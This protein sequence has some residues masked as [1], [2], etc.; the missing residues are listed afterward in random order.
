MREQTYLY[1]LC[2]GRG[3][4]MGNLTDEIPKALLPVHGLPM[5]E[6]SIN[7]F[8]LAF[9]NMKVRCVGGYQ[10]IKL[11]N[12]INDCPSEC[13][14]FPIINAEWNTYGPIVSASIAASDMLGKKIVML[15]NGDTLY[16]DNFAEQ[17][18]EQLCHAKEEIYLIG[19]LHQF[20]DDDAMLLEVEGGLVKKAGKGLE[21]IHIA[22]ESS[23]FIVAV[24]LNYTALLVEKILKMSDE[25]KKQ[26][27]KDG[28]W[29]EVV[30]ALSNDGVSI[31]F[32]EVDYDS[33][34]EC[35]TQ[36]CILHAEAEMNTVAIK[37][38]GG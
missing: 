32:V 2:A 18:K 20:N 38:D 21:P 9:D 4:R 33:W 25:V 14:I 12:W 3:S 22:Y 35:D 24:G 8:L 27:R 15:A 31:N 10:Y 23:G 1:M 28:P 6:H 37:N 34:W 30:N 36:E 13:F 19:S 11:E 7:A 29:H 17:I 5:L 16:G 26:N